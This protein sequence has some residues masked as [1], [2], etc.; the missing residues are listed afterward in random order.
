MEIKNQ[1][2][3]NFIKLSS[4]LSVMSMSPLPLN[5]PNLIK[6]KNIDDTIRIGLVGCGGRGTGAVNDALNI[7][8]NLELH[9]IGDIFR[10][11]IDS[12]LYNLKELHG[13]KVKVKDRKS[14]R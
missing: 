12:S 2:R 3:R 11:R 8:P 10:D 7:D 4:L 5:V 6:E 14:T 1:N 13:D 9:S